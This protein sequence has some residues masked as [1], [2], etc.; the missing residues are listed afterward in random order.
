LP[1]QIRRLR[2][3]VAWFPNYLAPFAPVG[4]YAVTVHDLAVFLHAE[5][6]TWQKRILQRSAIPFLVRHAAAVLT[7]SEAT[8]RDLLALVPDL[9]PQRVVAIHLAPPDFLRRTPD[10]ATVRRVRDELRLPERY[11]LAVGTLEPRK[12]LPRLLDAF[13]QA[14]AGH[15]GVGLVVAGGKGWRDEGIRKA[16]QASPVRD[17]IHSVGYVSR[18]ALGVLYGQADVMAYPSLYEGFGLPVV[19]AMAAGAPVLTSRG[20][21]LDEVALDAAV[22]VDPLSVDA[23]ATGLDQLLRDATLRSDLRNKGDRR[24]QELSWRKTAERTRAALL[25][26]KAG[27]LPGEAA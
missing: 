11:V 3:D 20:S 24:V 26:V 4:P 21:S 1:A 17:R 27:E 9:N 16:L 19:E 12:N 25:R 22:V 7:P 18:E 10:S 8:R 5:T 15:P 23:I 6:F 2:P 13:A 14:A